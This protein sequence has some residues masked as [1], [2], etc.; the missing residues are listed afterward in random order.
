MSNLESEPDIIVTNST[1]LEEIGRSLS[2]ERPLCLLLPLARDMIGRPKK[3]TRSANSVTFSSAIE[4][5]SR[6]TL[7]ES[8]GG[9]RTSRSL[10]V[11][12]VHGKGRLS[13]GSRAISPK[14]ANCGGAGECAARGEEERKP[15]R[16]PLYEK[17]RRVSN[18]HWARKEGLEKTQTFSGTFTPI[19]VEAVKGLL[20]SYS[21]ALPSLGVGPSDAI[22]RISSETLISLLS[23]KIG[24]RYVLI[25]CR[26]EYE[27]AG[28]HISTA[29]NVMTQ[30]GV[31][32]LFNSCLEQGVG[33]ETIF[34]FYC[35]YSSVRAPRLAMFMR[36]EDRRQ[37]TYPYLRFP[38]LY[39][40]TGGYKDFYNKYRDF[41]L[42][43]NY[44]PMDI[45]P[46]TF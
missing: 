19:V 31:Y 27:Y 15:E 7:E 40:M 29:E 5:A 42:P 16:S 33:S 4:E 28:G 43:R 13:P 18:K 26:F 2:D 10:F 17:T 38:H 32:H 30:T 39:I 20:P 14:G 45:L 8:D 46:K 1:E 23:G 36:N 44:V 37:S 35:E 24:G 6:E 34:V 11:V 22:L 41:C 25:D 21:C 9:R 12:G 3:R